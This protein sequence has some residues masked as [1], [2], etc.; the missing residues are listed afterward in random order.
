ML[1]TRQACQWYP[2][3]TELG[4]L[5][6]R[7]RTHKF[8]L[9]RRACFHKATVLV[10]V[11]IEKYPGPVYSL[12]K[13]NQLFYKSNEKKIENIWDR[14]S[15]SRLIRFQFDQHFWI[16]CWKVVILNT[17]SPML[18]SLINKLEFFFFWFE[19]KVNGFCFKNTDLGNYWLVLFLSKSLYWLSSISCFK[20]LQNL[21][22]L[23]M[24]QF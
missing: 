3:I 8:P 4:R 6:A 2:L 22:N 11:Y 21:A 10:V 19:S 12:S 16:P 17:Y 23:N 9:T 20:S 7:V 14:F 5:P 15:P 13:Q 18:C 24:D 1:H